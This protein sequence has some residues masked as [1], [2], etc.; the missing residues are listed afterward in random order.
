MCS[1]CV[2]RP[3]SRLSSLMLELICASSHVTRLNSYLYK[4]IQIQHSS[5][6]E[7]HLNSDNPVLLLSLQLPVTRRHVQQDQST[8]ISTYYMHAHRHIAGKG[9]HACT[10][11]EKGAVTKKKDYIPFLLH[12]FENVGRFGFSRFIMF[13]MHLNITYVQVHSKIYKSKKV[14][15]TYILERR[16]YFVLKDSVK[17]Y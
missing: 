11:Q 17:M 13:A 9:G 5:S 2:M 4:I 8:T 7:K 16:E 3:I 15:T 10:S 1:V 12:P 14:K 6:R